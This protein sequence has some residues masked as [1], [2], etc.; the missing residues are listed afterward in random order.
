MFGLRGRF[1]GAGHTYRNR[2]LI[3]RWLQ[4]GTLAMRTAALNCFQNRFDIEHSAR[5]L[6][7]IFFGD[8]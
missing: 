1:C 2:S 6:M 4:E 7:E 3:E 5:E 8:G